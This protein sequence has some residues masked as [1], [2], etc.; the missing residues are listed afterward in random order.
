[1]VKHIHLIGCVGVMAVAAAAA[2]ARPVTTVTFQASRDNTMFNDPAATT[3][4]SNGAGDGIYVGRT[5]TNGVRRGLLRF[6]LTSIPPLSHVV[7][8]TVTL[9]CVRSSSGASS[10][11]FEE[12][13]KFWGEST[14]NSPDGSGAPAEPGDATWLRT[15]FPDANWTTPGGDF[16]VGPV[17]SAVVSG[18]GTYSWSG[19]SLNFTVRG[20][21]N[22]PAANT[23]LI[24]IGDETPSIKSAKKF[25]SRENDDSAARPKLVVTFIPPCQ[26]DI[27]HDAFVNTQDLTILLGTFGQTVDPGTQGDISLDGAV[28]TIDLTIF[29]G[30]FGR[31]C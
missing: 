2:L 16:F 17:A 5:L 20:W 3:E 4:L 27:N 11:R 30:Q 15:Q 18:T 22:T 13:R 7:S 25:A 1:M 12:P 29:L 26:G 31:A 10:V 9:T 21:I 19:P 8:A 6:D 28:N 23:G 24:L 14:S